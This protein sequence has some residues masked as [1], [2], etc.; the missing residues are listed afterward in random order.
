MAPEKANPIRGAGG[1]G[2][3]EVRQYTSR[4]LERKYS[5]NTVNTAKEPQTIEELVNYQKRL[6]RDISSSPGTSMHG[7]YDSSY[8]KFLA[9]T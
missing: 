6:R 8:S 5:G 9:N 3:G 2:G 1:G 4:S 7:K